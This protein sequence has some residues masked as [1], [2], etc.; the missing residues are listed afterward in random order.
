MQKTTRVKGFWR[1]KKGKLEYV[2]PHTRK[3]KSR[4]SM[5]KTMFG[6]R[7]YEKYKEIVKMDTPESARKSIEKLNQEFKN[8]QS[9]D[10][11]ER[12]RKVTQEAENIISAILKRPNLSSKERVE[13]KE[14]K[15][16]YSETADA[17]N[18]DIKLEAE[19]HKSSLEYIR[20]FKEE[21]IAKCK[22]AEREAEELQK[23]IIYNEEMARLY[24][25]KGN[26]IEA[27]KCE[28]KIERY[29][30]GI[31]IYRKVHRDARKNI[32]YWENQ[33]K[34]H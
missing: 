31:D 21:E 32:K 5:N 28:E 26:K 25:Q 7:K 12:I 4:G 11:K 23:K 20:A 17:F 22:K 6:K 1:T 33:A 24:I 30:R 10:K 19:T 8:A 34:E 2:R 9:H 13:F 14:I 15:K 27:Q 3:V 18:K 16:M 29:K